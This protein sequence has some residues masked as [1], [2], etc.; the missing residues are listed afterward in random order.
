MNRKSFTIGNILGIPVGVD[1]SWILIMAL[2]TWSLATS[3]FPA[4]FKNWPAVTYWLVGG[5]TAILFFGSVFLHELSHSLVAERFKISVRK[6]TLYIFG[7]VTEMKTEPATA[8]SE[9]WITISGPLTNLALAGLFALLAVVFSAIAPAQALLKYLAFINLTLGA[10]NLIPGYPLDGGSVLMAIIWG[11]THRRH[12]GVVAATFIGSLVANLL[13]LWGVL[14][15]VGGDLWNGLW[16]AFIG[17]FMLNASGGELRQERLKEVLSGHRVAEAMSN[18]YTVIYPN[19]TLQR[20]VDDHILGGSRRYFIVEKEGQ[21]NGMTT[22]HAL[23]IVRK[24]DWPTTTV[25]QVMI[26]LSRLITTQPATELYEAL[27]EMDRDGVNQLPVIEGDQIQ[28]I[29]TR[30][31]VISYLRRLQTSPMRPK[32][33][34]S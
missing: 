8:W 5:L 19:T 17:W 10:F 33:A 3:Y 13:I 22:I 4:E 1:F 11:I 23:Q 34:S 24:E 6:I 28:G 29:L 30:E 31:D 7:G 14:Q 21:I 20:L 26:P 16:T 15:V 2:V 27:Q 25:E 32:P 9:F 18:S 12:W